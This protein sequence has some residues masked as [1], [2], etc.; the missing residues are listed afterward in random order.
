MNNV[1]VERML[2]ELRAGPPLRFF[3]DLFSLA[4]S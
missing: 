2:R 1:R 3:E 4:K